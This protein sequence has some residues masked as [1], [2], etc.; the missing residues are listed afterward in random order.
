MAKSD[1]WTTWLEDALNSDPFA[2][3]DPTVKPG[4]FVFIVVGF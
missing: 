4:D 1:H 3:G 2:L